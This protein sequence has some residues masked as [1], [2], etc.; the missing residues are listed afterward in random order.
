MWL[1]TQASQQERANNTRT[2]LAVERDEIVGYYATTPYRLE[3]DELATM[4]GVGKRRY[5]V[6]AVLLARL[7]V[8]KAAQ[9]QGL[10]RASSSMPSPKSPRR[11]RVLGSRW[12]WCT[13][14]MMTPSLSMPGMGSS[15]SRTTLCICT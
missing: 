6:P 15:G 11:P 4:Y 12:L 10:V 9:G 1:A 2:F 5:P 8:D 14:S 7:A 3:L 13:R